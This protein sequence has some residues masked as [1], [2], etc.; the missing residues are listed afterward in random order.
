M[1][2]GR[3]NLL[4][5]LPLINEQS[6]KYYC[7]GNLFMRAPLQILEDMCWGAKIL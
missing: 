4:P 3:V 7:S 1:K 2:T 5:V 6:N